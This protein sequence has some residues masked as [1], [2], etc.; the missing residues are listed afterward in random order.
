MNSSLGNVAKWNKRGGARKEKKKS[1]GFD[2]HERTHQGLSLFRIGRL[3][4][5]FFFLDDYQKNHEMILIKSKGR[6]FFQFLRL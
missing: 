1:K 6:F 2:V 5:L 3:L 4:F